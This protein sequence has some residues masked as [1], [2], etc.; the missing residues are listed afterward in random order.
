V[1]RTC[2][3]CGKE[4]ELTEGEISF[5]ESKGLDLPKRCKECREV[6]KSGKSASDAKR[7]SL[8]TN[9]TASQAGWPAGKLIVTN[10]AAIA[11]VLAALIG[12]GAL[13]G[14]VPGTDLSS[15]TNNDVVASVSNTTNTPNATKAAAASAS[16]TTDAAANASNNSTANTK[17][18]TFRNKNLLNEHYE[19]HG[20][21]M[22]FTDASAYE[23]AA[24]AVVTN[25]KSLHKTEKEDGDD[26]YYLETTREFVVVSTDG[27]IRTYYYADKDYFERQ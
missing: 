1:K 10:I 7:E 5:Y 8:T 26:V 6:N 21:S 2:K 9:K 3:Q 22:G 15:T 24:S 25:T 19:K 20:K 14:I 27:Y 23:S 13:G 18:Y 16:N 17:K 4:F 12:G 11:I